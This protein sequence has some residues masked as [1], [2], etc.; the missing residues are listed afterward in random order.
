MSQWQEAYK[1]DTT[2]LVQE[3]EGETKL[4]RNETPL[5]KARHINKVRYDQ[6][7]APGATKILEPTKCQCQMASHQTGY[8]PPILV[9]IQMEPLA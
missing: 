6:W 2:L 5:K 7:V 8:L 9:Y 4:V 3:R 1:V